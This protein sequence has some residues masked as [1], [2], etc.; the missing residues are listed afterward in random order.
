MWHYSKS[1][2]VRMTIDK[3]NTLQDAMLEFEVYQEMYGGKERHALGKYSLN[4]AEYAKSSTEIVRRHLLHDSKVNSTLK[5]GIQLEQTSG[6]EDFI[7]PELKKAQVFGGITGLLSEAKDGTS[8]EETLGYGA[9]N[10]AE[11]DK[12]AQDLE[13]DF[14]R[15]S[16]RRRWQAEAGELDPAD[17]IDDIFHGGEG[18]IKPHRSTTQT[19]DDY[20]STHE[21]GNHHHRQQ[22][23]PQQQPG[24]HDSTVWSP[25]KHAQEADE[26]LRGLS[27]SIDAKQVEKHVGKS[28][29]QRQIELQS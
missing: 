7:T 1:W 8:R 20:Q 13:Q 23:Q 15:N 6:D 14:Y 3:T 22:Q 5:L 29:Q 19:T 28:L 2:T 21:S 18:W 25:E 11:A 26:M 12:L 27:W 10:E 24:H 17:V 16:M 4:L 9:N